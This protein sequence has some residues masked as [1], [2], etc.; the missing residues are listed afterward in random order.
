M[1]NSI[2]IRRNLKV[3]VKSEENKLP[4][5]YLATVL[6]NMESLGFTFSQP[7][8]EAV[9]TL[10]VDA[11]TSFYKELVKS[12]KE[13]VGAHV[14]FSPMYPNFPQQVMDM[15][16]AELYINAIIHYVTLLLPVSKVNER[17]PLLDRVDLKVIDLGSE[18]DFNQMISQLIGANSSISSTDKKD[19]EWALT[20]AEDVSL[21]LPDVIPHKENMSFIIGALLKNEKISADD[22]AKYFKT[23]TDVLR[24]AVALSE[25]DVSLASSSRF[26]KFKR[27]ERR[28]LLDLLEQCGNIAEDMLR[29]K[30]RWIRLGEILHPAEYRTRFPK[31]N[32][33]FEILRNNIKFETFNGKVEAALLNRDIIAAKNLLTTR[34]GEFAR[35]LDHLVRLCSDE[36]TDVFNILEGFVSV[37]G[38]VST[39]VLLQVMAHFKHRND[40]NELRT[41]F[42]KGNVAKAIGIENTLPPIPENI[43]LMIVKICEDALKNRFAELPSLGKVFLD[44]Q[45]K[46]YL[47]PFSQRSA[48]KSLRTL[49]RGSKIDLPEGDTIRFFLWWKEGYV[50]GQHTGCVDIDLSAVIYD[51]DWQYKEHVSFTNLRSKE[52]KAYHS[53]D[54]TS[55]PNGASE[56]IDFDIP[57]VLKYDGRYVVMSLNSYTNQPYKDLP[58]CFSGWMVRQYPGSGEIFEPSTVQDKVDI[59]ADTQISIPVILDL[60]ERKLIWTD[61]SLTRDLTYCNTIEANQKGMVLVGKS[62]T[63][64]VKPNLYDLF[65]LHLEARGELVQD[66]EEAESIFSLDKGITPFDIETIISDY[67]ADFKR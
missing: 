46:N 18:E 45:L 49:V 27:A 57:S 48:S 59:T 10:S 6:K 56:F 29:Y 1:K 28:F 50:N 8:I 3:I 17:F 4:D 20:H 14:Q 22:A 9:Q 61:L 47:V 66:I 35:R 43:C 21:F 62:L 36:S 67:I 65:R 53:G 42:P 7:L 26:K 64:L 54:I 2:Y 51:E 37:I 15:S 32:R 11:F 58:E 44:E 19:V 5:V 31:A 25:G 12:L 13:M 23:A 34:P 39:P 16:C 24:L 63:S 40:N 33:A 30:K 55:A 60:K 38:D 52:F 41:F